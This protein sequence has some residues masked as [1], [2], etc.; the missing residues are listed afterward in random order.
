MNS[1]LLIILGMAFLLGLFFIPVFINIAIKIGWMDKPNARKIHQTP[2]ALIGGVSIVF[3]TALTLLLAKVGH[4]I[5]AE[6]PVMLSGALLLTIVGFL[7][8]KMDIKAKI[9]LLIQLMAAFAV[10]HSGIRIESMYGFLGIREI[11]VWFQY[12]LTIVVIT[13]VTNAFNL[14]DGMDGL[15]GTLGT[16]IFI[17]LAW[18]AWTSGAYSILPLFIALIGA[19]VAFLRYNMNPA[20]LFMG[21]AGSLMIGF[22]A[23]SSGVYLLQHTL[24]NDPTFATK[25]LMVVVTLFMIPVLDSLRVF[26][27]RMKKGMSPF[28]ADKTHL[29]HLCLLLGR[30]QRIVLLLITIMFLAILGM[31]FI[32]LP[33][34]GIFMTWTA[35]AFLF[36]IFSKLLLLNSDMLSWEEK[37]RIL[38]DY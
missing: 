1:D 27:G 18:I 14:M 28:K 9:K 24:H 19:T 31:G 8:D 2:I 30:N 12:I 29:H 5:L 3:V 21:D 32:L 20:R 25:S 13:G 16:T 22:L 23:S 10:A 34:I 36:V 26:R 11:P 4:I 6:Q 15:A 37:I 38:E 33:Y 7:D 35:Q 17:G